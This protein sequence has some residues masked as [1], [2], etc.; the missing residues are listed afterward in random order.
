M[1]ECA[2]RNKNWFRRFEDVSI[3]KISVFRC[4]D[5]TKNCLAHPVFVCYVFSDEAWNLS[6][7]NADNITALHQKYPQTRVVVVTAEFDSPAFKQQACAYLEV[8]RRLFL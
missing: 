1:L 3:F 4:G 5:L 7:I 2:K 8:S 6:P